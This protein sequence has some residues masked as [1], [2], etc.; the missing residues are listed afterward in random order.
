VS[1]TIAERVLLERRLLRHRRQKSGLVN[2]V[3]VGVTAIVLAPVAAVLV[4]LAGAGVAYAALAGDLQ[5]GLTKLQSL[6]QRQMFETTRILDR[7][8]TVLREVFTE[9][10]R[11]YIP[12]SD[13]P[14]YV[15]Q[16]TLAV[17]DK[18]FY[19]N[20]GIDVNGI[21]RA[22]EGELTGR[23][24]M[25]GGSTIT[26]QFVRHV[27]FSYEER[28][29]RSYTRKAKE[30]IL[31]LMLTRTYSKDQILEWY[32][33]EIYYGNLA[34]GIEAA[35]QTVFGKS[36][37]D[38]DLSEAALLAGL[39]QLPGTLDPLSADPDVQHRVRNRQHVVLNLMA[40]NGFITQHQAD[41]AAEEQLTYNDPDDEVF[42]APHF[43]VYV[44]KLLEERIDP[45]LLA[46]G[47]LVVTTTL[48]LSLQQLGE[49]Q[50]AEQVDKLRERN[51]MTNGALVALEPASGQVLAMVGSTDYWNDEIDGR[52]NVTIR[53]RQP[54]SSIKP[55]TYVTAL[56]RGMPTSSMLWDTRMELY[57]PEKMEPQ[58][59]DE[60]FHGPVRLREALANSYNIPALKLLSTIPAVN[61]KAEPDL[62]AGYMKDLENNYPDGKS[63]GN[64][65]A[66]LSGVDLTV[67][68]AHRMGVQGLN[69]DPWNYG[70]SLTL[71]GGEVTLLDL[72]T[73]YATLANGGLRV[74]PN[75]ILRI[76]DSDGNVLYDLS[77]D[78]AALD[79]YRAVD[80]RAA[81]IVTDILSD[82]NARTPAFGA[83]SPLNIGVPVAAK[84]GTTNDYKD[85]WTLGYTPYLT[86]GVWAGNNDGTPMKRS[87]GITGAAPIWSGFMRNVAADRDNRAIVRQAREALG[88]PFTTSFE[89]P[90]GVVERQICRLASLRQPVAGC[91]EFQ[92][93]LFVEAFLPTTGAG[94]AGAAPD[95]Q[96]G[97]P[98]GDGIDVWRSVPAVVVPMPPAPPEVVAAAEK[99]GVPVPWPP[100]QLCQPIDGGPGF[101][102]AQAV[103]V[104]PLPADEDERAFVVEWAQAN[105]WIAIEPTTPC[106]G[107]MAA[108]ALPP[109]SLPGAAGALLGAGS[110]LPAVTRAEYRLNLVAGST[111]RARTVLT[112]TVAYNPAEVEYFKVELG[113]GREPSEWITLGDVHREQ[114]AGGPLETLDAPSLPAG[115]YIVRLVLVKTDGNFLIPPYS[116][117]IRIEH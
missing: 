56:E 61:L 106:T 30:L 86:V 35:A 32:L 112:G 81:Y 65:V 71:G 104:L 19:G 13:I 41:V 20:P 74:R 64:P 7:N 100:V 15:R 99:A 27:A 82:N 26:Q 109:G 77:A 94:G 21:L 2:V 31:A 16:A 93:E 50:V 57:I 46:R 98:G 90:K 75:P 52:V 6:D 18:S 63:G 23:P 10:R 51:H 25:G 84:T 33:N 110:G 97:A 80:E 108:A 92:T 11:D 79:P 73:A 62:F 38:L 101:D 36:A 47:G 67:A 72:T 9:G 95:A 87:S 8:G 69:K 42:L 37:G 91:Q 45:Q 22:I 28:T 89:R 103:A 1:L 59:Y 60:K 24:G 55:I 114:V 48:D 4:G 105:G 58:N 78:E 54:G 40:Q 88:F 117:P 76:T 14:E 115:D 113:A 3:M 44:R 17:E 12:L 102:K 83:S 43:V 70:L 116:V 66:A 85:N 5:Q 68:T 39:P 107:E 53:D 96:A 111:L 29:A 49:R 34:Y